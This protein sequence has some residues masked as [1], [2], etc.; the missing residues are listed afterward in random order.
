MDRNSILG[1]IIIAGIL[2]FFVI[3]NQPSEEEVARQQKLKDSLEI[4]QKEADA[5]EAIAE[6]QRNQTAALLPADT[7]RNDSTKAEAISKEF[8]QFSNAALGTTSFLTVETDLLKLKFSNKGGKLYSVELKEYKT[9][10]SLPL[11]LFN[12][13]STEFGIGLNEI[14]KSTL[15]ND[16]SS[17]T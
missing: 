13:D 2:G 4:V 9:Y 6:L 15:K 17:K 16:L 10:D 12:G 14:G 8:G 1:L 5:K 7:L 3:Y 11:L